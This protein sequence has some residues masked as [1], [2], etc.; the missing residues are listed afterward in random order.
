MKGSKKKKI[1]VGIVSLFLSATILT[2]APNTNISNFGSDS[3]EDQIILKLKF[4]KPTENFGERKVLSKLRSLN[5][6]EPQYTTFE[7]SISIP[8]DISNELVTSLEK[9]NQQIEKSK[10]QEEK[11][12]LYSDCLQLLR[13][14]DILPDGF[15]ME[16]ILE[17]T[18]QISE[19]ISENR[20]AFPI[21]IRNRLPKNYGLNDVGIGDEPFPLDNNVNQGETRLDVGSAF[22]VFMVLSEMTPWN[23]FMPF[24]FATGNETVFN[25]TD[26]PIGRVLSEIIPYS[27]DYTFPVGW[28]AAIGY[29]EVLAIPGNA[30][31]GGQT[32]FSWP[33]AIP[34]LLYIYSGAS[35]IIPIAYGTASLTILLD[36]GPRQVPIPLVDIGIFGSV[37]TVHMPY[38][39]EQN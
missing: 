35:I 10:N 31:I 19:K 16:A 11:I 24:L 38:A 23:V 37:L 18:H 1:A 26:F 39:R 36:R 12:A 27:E 28:T 33:K 14:N 29:A 34:M 5:S 6:R 22:F 8:S 17:T 32:L 15:T 2:A 25:L 3:D 21:W 7:E 9:L 20:D 30:L 13:N 4:S